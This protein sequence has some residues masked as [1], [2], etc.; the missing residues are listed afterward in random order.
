MPLREHCRR[1]LP[2]NHR[3][4]TLHL[5]WPAVIVAE[6]N[7]R[8]PDRYVAH[9]R[10]Y[11]G[12]AFEIDVAAYEHPPGGFSG[13]DAADGGVAVATTVQAPPQPTL[14][15]AT[16]FPDGDDLEVLVYDLEFGERLAAAIELVSPANKD[17]P[18][19]RRAFVAKCGAMLL[20]RVSVTIVDVITTRKA[21]LYGELLDF[22]GVTDPSLAEK[23]PGLYA[24]S[25]RWLLTR[26]T[27]TVQTWAHTLALGRSLPTLP[28]WLD[29]D[30]WV[31][32][33]LELTYEQTCKNL[34]MK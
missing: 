15:V 34:R 10:V 17:R 12:S 3:W 22:L 32:L 11:V 7:A 28:L 25:C 31:P 14:T 8:L 21:N 13:A 26:P 23:P 4:S 27:G 19:S 24:T 18:E 20:H 5:T 6:L 1:P 2:S 9:P 30:F 16:E 29:E 33:D